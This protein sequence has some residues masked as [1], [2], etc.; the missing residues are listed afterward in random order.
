METAWRRL[1]LLPALAALLEVSLRS[2]A[3]VPFALGLVDLPPAFGW[4]L[5][6]AAPAWLLHLAGGHVR[7]LAVLLTGL[8]F[9]LLAANLAHATGLGKPIPLPCLACGGALLG[10]LVARRRAPRLLTALAGLGL[11][12]AVAHA[13][14][15]TRS[16]DTRVPSVLM[17]VMDTTSAQH[18]S[19]YGYAQPTSPNLDALATRSLVFERAVAAAPWTVPSHAAMFSGLY[20]AELGFDGEGLPHGMLAGSIA[21]DLRSAGRQTYGVTANPLL[22]AVSDLDR[23]FQAL[24]PATALEQPLAAKLWARLRDVRDDDGFQTP[25]TRITDLA[26][27]WL[28]RLSTRGRPWFLFLNYLDPHSPY[29]PPAAERARFAPGIDADAVDADIR[30]Y[31]S[32]RRPLTPAVQYAISGLYDGEIAAVDAAVGR[33][34]AELERRGFDASNLVVVVTADHGESLGERGFVGHL[35]GM[36]D[37]VLHVPLLVSGPGVAAGRVSEPVQPVQL[38][39]SLRAILGLP[40]LPGIAPALPPWGRAPEMLVTQKPENRWYCD[41][42]RDV[43][44]R[45]DFV[46]RNGSWIALERRGTKAVFNDR[47][48]GEA[49]D[50]QS[51]PAERH[52]RPLALA[53][54]M[55]HDYH[56]LSPA[57]VRHDAGAMGDELR[58]ALH[59]IGYVGN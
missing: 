21:G 42:M 35:L 7:R 25:A 39:A 53:A 38:R 27:D 59:A 41:E 32:G 34:L 24:W 45:P 16:A 29:R 10:A 44:Q 55:V 8:P 51:D 15:T 52:P 58:E 48:E 22:H 19:T 6:A 30:S 37:E 56:Q 17:I 18:L 3:P 2:I 12:L 23:G 20:P 33:L 36:P 46:R 1:V 11:V 13:S 49:Y 4:Y 14:T 57:A 26:L 50:L 9:A 40:P 5:V 43:A 31:N 28:D 47:G 54:T